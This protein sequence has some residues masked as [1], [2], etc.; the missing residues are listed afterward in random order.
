MGVGN[1]F[2]NAILEILLVL[3]IICL[4]AKYK[5]TLALNCENYDDMAVNSLLK[6]NGKFC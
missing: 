2:T 6:K 5:V 3:K 1:Q 4:F